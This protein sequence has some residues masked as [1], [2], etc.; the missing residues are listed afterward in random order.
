MNGYISCQLQRAFI[1]TGLGMYVM[2]STLW[3]DTLEFEEIADEYFTAS[4]GENGRE[5]SNYLEKLSKM[6]YPTYINDKIEDIDE[7]EAARFEAVKKYIEEFRPFIKKNLNSGDEC[8]DLSFWYL[9]YHSEIAASLAEILNFRALKNVDK[10]HETWE[11]LRNMLE[12]EED[13]I[14]RGLDV[15]QY[16]ETMNSLFK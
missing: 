1:P 11:K 10:V 13:N 8:R 14:Q 15:F 9:K 12:T 6:F 5:C 7:R 16:I 3:D 4:F 2:S